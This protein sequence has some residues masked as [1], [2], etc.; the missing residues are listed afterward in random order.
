MLYFTPIDTQMSSAFRQMIELV[1]DI[2]AVHRDFLETRAT[3][4]YSTDRQEVEAYRQ[5]LK[6][7]LYDARLDS[8]SVPDQT[9]TALA[10]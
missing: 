8:R 6:D 3:A 4:I 9:E 7:L 5:H 10:D 2:L 1:E